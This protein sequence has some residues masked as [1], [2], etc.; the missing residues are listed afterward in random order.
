MTQTARPFAVPNA[1]NIGIDSFR[2][3]MCFAVALLHALPSVEG[4][5]AETWATLTASVCRGAVPFFFI[6]SGFFM[7]VPAT[8]KME[9]VAR[10][11]GRLLPIY[12]IWFLVYHVIEA[13][14]LGRFAF[15]SIRDLITGGAGF[16][17]WFIP[18]LGLTLSATPTAIIL[19]GPRA[20]TAATVVIGSS[21]WSL[22]HI[23][24]LLD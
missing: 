17:L 4:L 9:I 2:Y 13:V 15:P 23:M 5:T 11:L 18:V 10:P 19:V 22:A 3:L 1:R 14:S 8:W 24:R 20:T 21:A 6:A 7:R 16:H 12:A